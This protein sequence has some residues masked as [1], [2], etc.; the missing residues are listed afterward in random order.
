LNIFYLHKDPFKAAEYQYNKHVVKMILESAQ[1]LCTAHHYYGNGDNVPYKKTHLNHPSTVWA[2][3]NS[4]NYY[5]LYNHML[6][7]GQEYTKRY[8]KTH[9][10][11]TKCCETLQNVPVGMPLGG[12]ITQPPQCMPDEYKDECSI[13]AYWNYYLGDKHSVANSNETIKTRI[14]EQRPN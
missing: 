4:R 13:K 1:I 11:I 8:G 2:R 9:L 12:P 7:L 10:T 14:Y 5:W 6:A 3:E